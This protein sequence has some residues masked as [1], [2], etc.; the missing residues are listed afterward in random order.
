METALRTLRKHR[1]ALTKVSAQR[2]SI[3]ASI[4]QTRLTATT[5]TV[6]DQLH[7]SLEPIGILGRLIRSPSQDAREADSDTRL[8]P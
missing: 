6:L 1:G 2:L 8:V 3:A 4:R 7:Q 5:S